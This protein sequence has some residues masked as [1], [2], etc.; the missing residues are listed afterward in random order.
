[1]KVGEAQRFCLAPPELQCALG[2]CEEL[3]PA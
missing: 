2:P 3:R 1:V